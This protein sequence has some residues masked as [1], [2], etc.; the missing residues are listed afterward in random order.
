MFAAIE[1]RARADAAT[2]EA[3]A[4]LATVMVH[5][6]AAAGML[7]HDPAVGTGPDAWPFRQT[8]SRADGS[9]VQCPVQHPQFHFMLCAASLPLEHIPTAVAVVQGAPQTLRPHTRVPHVE[10]AVGRP[11]PIADAAEVELLLPATA[12]VPPSS[13]S[14]AGAT[15]GQS[16]LT[17]AMPPVRC[18]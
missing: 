6:V 18:T 13:S 8:P 15:P 4:C 12:A 11:G 16:V 10:Q 2:D 14:T 17:H 9:D 3:K 1:V 5:H 7:D